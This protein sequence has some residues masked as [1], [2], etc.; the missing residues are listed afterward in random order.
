M[1]DKGEISPADETAAGASAETSPES[2]GETPAQ[3]TS[4]MEKPYRALTLGIVS[5]VLLI[6]FEAMAVGTAMP[7][8]VRDLDGMSLYGLAFSGYFTT[9]LL[10]M[11]FSG[12]WCDVRGPRIPLVG[13]IAAFAA[14][15]VLSGT[16]QSMLPFVAG[17]A[18]Q[19]IGGGLVIVALYVVVGRT[20]P[21]SIRPK[22]FS[23]FSAA[24]VLPSIVG[25]PVSGMVTDH[26]GWRWVFLAIPALVVLP[27]LTIVP[28]LGKVQAE[29]A[30]DVGPEARIDRR[31]ILAAAG[32]SLGAGLL[33]YGGQHLSVVGGILL[34]AGAL[35]MLPTVPKLLPKGTLR[36]A[37]GL[38]SV[39]LSRGLLAGSFFAVESFVPLMLVSEHGFSPTRAGWTL[40][41]GA[42]SWALGSW[43]HGRTPASRRPYLVPIGF[44]L[45]S[46]AIGG[47]ALA[48]VPGISPYV[49][50]PAWFVGGIGMGLS[51]AA[52]STLTLDLSAPDEAGGNSAALQVSDA[53]GTVL[54]MSLGGA[55]FAALHNGEGQDGKVFTVIFLIL[56]GI[57]LLGSLIGP[58]IR[59]AK[60]PAARA[61]QDEAA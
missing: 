30:A 58:R 42:L 26:L 10:A 55:F 28:Q 1:L 39:I 27:M 3:P 46:C 34:G 38:P 53:L 8:A 20:Y 11:V 32:A 43:L 37:R 2:P 24:W 29:I 6:A 60:V 52:L 17:R 4:V 44:L 15:L 31:R 7:V 35:L 25:P 36:A 57:S 18:V 41:T 12:Q 16:A 54:L 50:L 22:V 9:S 61:A 5:V 59:P 48:L 40:T 49:V 45:V 23:A 13:G 14:G 51:I 21:P 56:L 47:A 19:G 33:Q